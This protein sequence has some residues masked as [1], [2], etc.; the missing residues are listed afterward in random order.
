MGISGPLM[1]GDVA[2]HIENCT[3]GISSVGTEVAH[4]LS[5]MFDSTHRYLRRPGLHFHMPDFLGQRLC[6]AADFLTELSALGQA[7]HRAA[8]VLAW[9]PDSVLPLRLGQT[10][11][12]LPLH[13]TCASSISY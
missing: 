10:R 4:K 2:L 6:Q 7:Q 9:P 11:H 1:K 3:F 12:R 5:H 8:I 13:R